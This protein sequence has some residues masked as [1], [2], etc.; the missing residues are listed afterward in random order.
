LLS[1]ASK[2]ISQIIGDI[3]IEGDHGFKRRYEVVAKEKALNGVFI[4]I[5]RI[6]ADIL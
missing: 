4:D 3:Q 5:W 2:T 6:C 1:H